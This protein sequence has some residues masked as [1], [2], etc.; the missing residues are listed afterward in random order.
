MVVA[1]P[2]P[3]KMDT[4]FQFVSSWKLGTYNHKIIIHFTEF[5]L[6]CIMTDSIYPYAQQS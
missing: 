5:N 1:M 6:T 3:E 4:A 2:I